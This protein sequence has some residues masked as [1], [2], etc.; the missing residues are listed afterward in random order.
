[1]KCSE[2]HVFHFCLE[3]PVIMSTLSFKYVLMFDFIRKLEH[4]RKS[5]QKGNLGIWKYA[6]GKKWK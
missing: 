1:M 5:Y 4:P 3:Y 6:L 2:F